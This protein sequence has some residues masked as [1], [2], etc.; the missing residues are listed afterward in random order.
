MSV[1]WQGAKPWGQRKLLLGN[2]SIAG[3]GC[4]LTCLVEAARLFKTRPLLTPYEANEELKEVDG[5]CI[6][7]NIVLAMAAPRFGLECPE[8][9]WV[10]A[11]PGHQSLRDAFERHLTP[12]AAA[13]V[14]VDHDGDGHGD[15][16][17]LAVGRRDDAIDCLD[18][19][20]AHHVYLSWPSLEVG[21]RWGKHDKIYRVVGFRP[22]K[23]AP[24]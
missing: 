3:A 23:P 6:G 19:A 17:L 9:G 22:V 4:V 18:P 8:E 5:A 12:G 10:Q 24:V 16:T 15:H 13:F 20:L 11:A 21:V 2:S 14:R 7:S 1:L